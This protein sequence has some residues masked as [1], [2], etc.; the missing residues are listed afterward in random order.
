LIYVSY[1]FYNKNGPK[2]KKSKGYLV[3]KIKLLVNSLCSLTE[4]QIFRRVFT[5]LFIF[6]LRKINN[7]KGS[8]TLPL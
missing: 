2:N 1:E 4:K 5:A 7:E 6:H 3:I 8:F